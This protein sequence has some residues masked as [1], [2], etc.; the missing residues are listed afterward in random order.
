MLVFL[1]ILFA[2]SGPQNGDQ[3]QVLSL[4]EELKDFLVFILLGK[5][6]R[7]KVTVPGRLCLFVYCL[8]VDVFSASLLP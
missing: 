5:M 1:Y 4:F 6:D 7:G 3:I 8:A 2:N